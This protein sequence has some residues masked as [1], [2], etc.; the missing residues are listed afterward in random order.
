MEDDDYD[1]NVDGGRSTKNWDDDSSDEDDDDDHSDNDDD[2]DDN[3]VLSKYEKC[4]C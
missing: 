1:H 2:D 4:V 3:I